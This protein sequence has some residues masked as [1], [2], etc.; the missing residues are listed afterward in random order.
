[1]RFR[2]TVTPSLG[3]YATLWATAPRAVAGA[4]DDEA[5]GTVWV[6]P[7]DSYSSSVGVLG[8]KVDTNRIAYWPAAVDCDNVCVELSL[9]GRTVTLLRVDQSQGAHDVSYDAWNY[10]QTGASARDR[11]TAG[12]AVAMTW[13]PRPAEACRGLIHTPGHRLPLSAA[14]SMNFLAACVTGRPDSWVAKNYVLYNVLDP[15]CAWG[16]DEACALPPGF[17]AAANQATCPS[18]LGLPD[19][20]DG[21]PVYNIRYP[22]GEEV[23]A[24]TGA[25]A[26]QGNRGGAGPRPPGLTWVVVVLGAVVGVVSGIGGSAGLL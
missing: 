3:L 17:P 14:N 9:G 24:V 12:G 2:D 10:L 26:E 22:T 15:L 21:D 13:K 16:R 6:T 8:C 7:H 25:P 20:L 4:G 1:M 11:P 5:G 19:A 18:A 23:N